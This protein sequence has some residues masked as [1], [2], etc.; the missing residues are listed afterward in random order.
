MTE[1]V[2]CDDDRGDLDHIVDLVQEILSCCHWDYHICSFLSATELLETVK[3]I[4]IAILDI[5]MG[6]MDGIELGKKVKARC[7]EAKIIYI[8]SY[9]QYCMQA[10]NKVHAYS[11]LCKPVK[12][13][14]LERPLLELL[15]KGNRSDEGAEKVFE[16]ILD[17]KGKAYPSLRLNLNDIIYF[18]YIKTTRR[19]AI[20]MEK[21]TYE[22][23]CVM[24]RLADE[25]KDHGFA[26]NCR[27]NLV[28]LRH[29]VK[30]KGYEIYMDNGQ[31][32]PLS[33]RRVADFKEKLN[34]FLNN[35][36]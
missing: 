36:I 4:H 33:Q 26:I 23:P 35:N 12:K 31:T 14:E 15:E 19:V 25:L 21:E 11:F 9:E 34:D 18:E 22:Y 24:E 1:I 6:T 16:K 10:I 28:N 8:T 13:E 2:I 5:S 30:I 29:V 3:R 7:P 20:T 32:R 17:S 27:G